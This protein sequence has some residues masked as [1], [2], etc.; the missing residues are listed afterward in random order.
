[1]IAAASPGTVSRF[2]MRVMRVL[3]A[4]AVAG[5]AA[6]VV[7]L[8]R[9]AKPGEPPVP[10]TF[11]SNDRSRWATVRALV[12]NGTFV[13]GSRTYRDKGLKHQFRK[14][15]AYTDRGIVFEQ[16]YDTVDAVLH[17]ETDNFYSSKPPLLSV[18]VAGEYWVMYQG[19]GWS[20]ADR[21]WIVVCIVLMTVNVLPFAICLWLFARMLDT[22]GKTDW[23]VIFTFAAACFGTFV[24]TFA[25]TL[26]NHTIAACTALFAVYPLLRGDGELS[27][28]AL[29]LSGFFAGLTACLELPALV[30][31]GTLFVWCFLQKPGRTVVTFIPAAMLPLA[32]QTGL[33]FL[34][35]GSFIP[36]YSHVGG[37][38]YQYEGSHWNAP[39][40]QQTG[41]D[42]AGEYEP[43]WLYA[44]HTLVGHHGIFSLTPLW[45]IA[46]AA[47][48]I[49]SARWLAR[50]RRHNLDTFLTLSLAVSL[51]VIV[52]YTAVIGTVNY[53]GW[54]SGPR[55]FFWLTPLWLLALLAGADRLGQTRTGR[56]MAEVCLA[57]SVFSAVYPGGNPWR[58]PW[59]Y[60]WMDAVGL[61]PYDRL[62]GS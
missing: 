29:I 1:M 19:L 56:W 25:N 16:H 53:G 31:V 28:G 32:V 27:I 12:E 22:Y 26:N 7:S 61:I 37:P 6:R 9:S 13:V 46:F 49:A 60:R 30:F 2:R 52:F 18:L 50:R 41:I 57:V 15:G 24:T 47:M 48:A 23:G 10:P 45:V 43:R 3:L 38:W 4:V 36:A 14:L 33:T 55:W 20:M 39:P 58:H 62:T 35:I 11:A 42:W 51:V 8:E 17:P 44:V 34:A 21:P 40:D 54:T 59:I 5:S